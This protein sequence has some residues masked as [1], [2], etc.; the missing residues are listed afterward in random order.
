VVVEEGRK[1]LRILSVAATEAGS[2]LVSRTLERARGNFTWS[3]V[4][5]IS[6][7]A[8]QGEAA[9]ESAEFQ[10]SLAAPDIV[11]VIGI[12]TSDHG[13]PGLRFAPERTYGS[14]LASKSARSVEP[15][16]SQVIRPPELRSAY[17]NARLFIL[18][19]HPPEDATD[20]LASDRQAANLARL[21]AADLARKG[22]RVIVIPPVGG[23]VGSDVLGR[24][25]AG[26]PDFLAKGA[27]AIL[28]TINRIQ[29]DIFEG[30]HAARPWMWE[31]ALDVCVFDLPDQPVGSA[32]G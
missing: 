16:T 26:V 8:L 23:S 6:D 25:Y 18:Q 15:A 4:P 5:G 11:H 1:H 7:V 3:V 27:G 29:M 31:L 12:V 2:A 20:R 24:L 28:P 14:Q 9:L 22:T 19:G 32:Q 10:E 17:P 21:F 30:G 13:G